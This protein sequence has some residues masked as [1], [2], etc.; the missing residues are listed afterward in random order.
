[1]R[2]FYLLMG[3]MIVLFSPTFAQSTVTAD[4]LV[5]EIGDSIYLSTIAYSP[6]DTIGGMQLWDYSNVIPLATNLTTIVDPMMAPSNVSF[7]EATFASMTQ[8]QDTEFIQV[9]DSSYVRL[10]VNTATVFIDYSVAETILKFPMQYQ[11]TFRT[12]FRGQY[13]SAGTT[14]YRE[15]ITRGEYDAY[16]T[17]ILPWGTITDVVRIHLVSTTSDSVDLGSGPFFFNTTTDSYLWIKEGAD[18]QLFGIYSVDSGTGALTQYA[19]FQE[20][21]S[22]S[23]AI[24]DGRFKGARLKVYP[25]PAKEQITLDLQ[26]EEAHQVSILIENQMGQVVKYLDQGL[27]G[28]G[29]HERAYDVSDLSAGV[30]FLRIQNEVGSIQQKIV[31]Q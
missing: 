10:G 23:T 28:F 6:P 8:T 15:G 31:K 2:S 3:A 12:E 4:F 16:G 9:T 26:L 1:M 18:F 14:V 11:D 19:V 13:E 30:Y 29:N 7:P 24:S 21:P 27:L 17:L 20:E 25:N 22:F 5:P